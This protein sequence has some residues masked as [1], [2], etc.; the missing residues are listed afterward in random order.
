MESARNINFVAEKNYFRS[1]ENEG[2][3][4]GLVKLMAG[5]NATLAEHIKECEEYAKAEGRNHITFLSKNFINNALGVIRKYLVKK[6]VGEINKNDGFFGVLM[7]GSQDLSCKEQISVVVRYVNESNNIIE[8]TIHLFNASKN[9]SGEGL[10]ESLRMGLT[11]VG[12]SLSNIVGCSF[13][14][15][16]SM[17]SNTI[18]VS[19]LIQ[20]DS[21]NCIYTW[22]LSHRFNLVMKTATNGPEI[23][24]ILHYAEESAKL[25]RN[26]YV[27]MNVWTEV[28]AA[29]PN[30]NSQRKL[31]LIGTT[32]WSS[33]QDAVAGIIGS[34]SSFFVLIKSLIKLCGLPNLDGSSL[35]LASSVLNFWLQ[36]KNVVM[37]F[38]LHKIFS[39]LVPTTKYLQNY[40]L[41]IVDGIKTLKA[42]FEK[43]DGDDMMPTLDTYIEEAKY[44]V[45]RSNLLLQNDTEIRVLDYECSITFPTEDETQQMNKEIKDIFRDF[46]NVLKGE[47]SQRILNDFDGSECDSILH[48]MLYLDP[49][50]AEDNKNFISF[51]K[52]CEIND[53]H[54]K[55]AVME[56]KNF[57]TAFNNRP[58][59]NSTTNN[60]DSENELDDVEE[61]NLSIENG[62]ENGNAEATATIEMENVKL[63]PMREKMCYCLQCIL[64][65]LTE[66]DRMK[67]Y[68]NIYRLYKYVATLPSTQVKCERD[69]SK[70]KIIKS[71]LRS[72]LGDDTLGNLLIISTESDMFE[73]ID[74]EDILDTIIATSDRI[75]LYMA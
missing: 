36:Y 55:T 63:K 50:Y 41:N 3:F 48:E 12:L 24:L 44:F 18:G 21:P 9:T 14:G 43:L 4:I 16:Y 54:E 70:M 19:A 26:S 45:Q 30:F 53:I 2:N 35:V 67:N 59:Y 42:C 10:Y 1:E 15:A 22:C 11:D 46:I 49:R 57:I 7:D 23:K 17:R 52:M 68:E 8:R 38:M 71:R 64:N 29:T 47:I 25:F 31:K 65:Y 75:S 39:L 40:G 66:D 73:N 6:I 62:D 56:M 27:R 61:I 20:Q 37:T 13:D 51:R 69:F 33:K 28:A 34:E 5:E 32:R 60:I 58:N 72:S 74:L